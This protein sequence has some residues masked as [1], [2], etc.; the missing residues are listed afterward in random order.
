MATDDPPK[1][2][3][4]PTPAAAG[5][6]A[7]APPLEDVVAGLIDE[8]P[9]RPRLSVVPPLAEAVAQAKP[10]PVADD[11]LAAVL[12]GPGPAPEEPLPVNDAFEQPRPT[13]EMPDLGKLLDLNV[14]SSGL[15]HIADWIDKQI[16]Q[17]NNAVGKF[18]S[19]VEVSF[20]AATEGAK[21]AGGTAP[22][23]PLIVVDVDVPAAAGTEPATAPA[24]ATTAEAAPEPTAGS[25]VA[26]PEAE[27]VPVSMPGDD[28]RDTPATD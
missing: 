11:P 6:P 20:Q 9:S 22:G 2:P 7:T 10:R 28:E 18:L 1:T 15:R 25:P 23:S 17:L 13:T 27:R 19:T 12:D 3:D 26:E 24:A 4:E 21:P 5:E 16:P 8:K 14:L